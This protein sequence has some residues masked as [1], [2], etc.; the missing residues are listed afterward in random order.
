M[1][2]HEADDGTR[3]FADEPC[4]R[5]LKCCVVQPSVHLERRSQGLRYLLGFVHEPQVVDI[6]ES[7]FATI[8]NTGEI[9]WLGV[10]D[11][12]RN[13]LIRAA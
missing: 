11:N 6:V 1:A 10:R 8:E 9:V 7:L 5:C 2:A 3:S 4:E 13:W 12:F